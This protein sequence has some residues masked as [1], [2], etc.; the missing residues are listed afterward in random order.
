MNVNDEVGT[1]KLNSAYPCIATRTNNALIMIAQLATWVWFD[2]LR[3]S[4]L[5]AKY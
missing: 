1:L 2:F 4:V 3:Y 5:T